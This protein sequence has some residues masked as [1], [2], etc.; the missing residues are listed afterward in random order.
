MKN[1]KKTVENGEKT[2]KMR[3]NNEKQWKMM[4]TVQSNTTHQ[5]LEPSF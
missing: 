5:L 3:K 2:M 4:K 1:G